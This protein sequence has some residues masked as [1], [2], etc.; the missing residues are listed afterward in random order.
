[1]PKKKKASYED[2]LFPGFT[3]MDVK[4]N[5]KS[6]KKAKKNAKELGAKNITWENPHR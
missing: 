5:P 3:C 1:M 2:S 6:N 4:T